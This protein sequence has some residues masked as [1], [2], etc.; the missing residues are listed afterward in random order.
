MAQLM[1]INPKKRKRRAST[2]SR[3]RRAAPR[4][5]RSSTRLVTRARRTGSRIARRVRRSRRSI[6]RPGGFVRG[7]LA[8][9][10]V[11]GMGALGVDL[12][13]GFLPLPAAVQT[14]ALK[15]FVRIGAAVALG[16]IASKIANKR[17]GEQVTA[18]A[19][20][21]VL[22]DT[23]KGGVRSVLPD[24]PGLSGYPQLSFVNAGLPVGMGEFV[25][26][27]TVMPL[28]EYVGVNY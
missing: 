11:G 8:P 3:K 14:G 4:R 5:R 13:L 17:L 9:A 24:L 26:N 15:P 10:A 7:T 1:L 16:M 12:M 19:L 25:A 28:G 6:N 21:V 2:S 22:Y 23:I 18:G 20:T 27:E